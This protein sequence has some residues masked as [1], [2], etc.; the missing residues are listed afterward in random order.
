M[1][2]REGAKGAKN[3]TGRVGRRGWEMGMGGM[4]DD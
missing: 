2:H 1:V 4:S 3:C